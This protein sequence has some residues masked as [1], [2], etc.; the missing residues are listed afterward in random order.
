MLLKLDIFNMGKKRKD[1]NHPLDVC[2]VCDKELYI[3]NIG[4]K[5]RYKSCLDAF[6]EEHGLC[7]PDE[8]R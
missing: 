3:K 7:K 8:D 6:A 1:G 4:G 2:E 5:R